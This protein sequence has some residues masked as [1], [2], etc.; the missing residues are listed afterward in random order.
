[1]RWNSQE[2]NVEVINELIIECDENNEKMIKITN[3][4]KR[5]SVEV[6]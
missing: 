1:M 4:L 5:E 3:K 2:D 6:M